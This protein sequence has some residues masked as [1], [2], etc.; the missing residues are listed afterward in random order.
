MSVLFHI[1]SHVIT[2]VEWYHALLLLSQ[3]QTQR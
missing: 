3:R 1:H 2:F